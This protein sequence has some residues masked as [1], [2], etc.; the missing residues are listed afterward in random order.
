MSTSTKKIERP[1]ANMPEMIDPERLRKLLGHSDSLAM[2]KAV[3]SMVINHVEIEQNRASAEIDDFKTN[4]RYRTDSLEG[5]CTCPESDGFEF[6]IHC[7]ALCMQVNK[8]SQQLT[9]LDKGPDKSKVMAYLLTMDKQSLSKR[10]LDFI[11]DDAELFDRYLIQASLHKTKIDYSQLKVR[12]TELTKLK[13]PMFSQRQVKHFFSKIQRF[14][15]ELAAVER[16]PEPEKMLKVVEYVIQRLNKV[17][18]ELEDNSGQRSACVDVLRQSY[19][20][21]FSAISG[22]D[23]T[24]V[25]R[26]L[27][28]WQTD[29]FELLPEINGLLAPHLYEKFQQEVSALLKQSQDQEAKNVEVW[30][31]QKCLRFLLAEAEAAGQADKVAYYRSLYR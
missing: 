21:L 15:E 16:Y 10:L 25:K 11:V 13:E 28:I 30:L 2:Q 3:E 6:C 29:R 18:L 12:V 26:V 20:Q 9:A 23:E 1:Y 19:Q 31:R 8:F 22:R 7:A 24:L 17:L 27:S 4:I 5:E 14:L